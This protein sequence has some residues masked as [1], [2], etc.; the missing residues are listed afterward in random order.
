MG[1]NINKLPEELHVA[2]AEMHFV[3]PLI[4]GKSNIWYNVYINRRNL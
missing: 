2:N 3:L 1:D 4:P